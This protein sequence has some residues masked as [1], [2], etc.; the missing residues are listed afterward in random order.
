MTTDDRETKLEH[1]RTEFLKL[2]SALHDRTTDLPAVPVLTPQVRKMLDTRHH[3]GVLHVEIS[4]LDDVES[5]YGWQVFDE[6]LEVV[7]EVLRAELAGTLPAGSLLGINGVGGD[8]FAVFVPEQ[9]SG[10]E[11][12]M[13]WLGDLATKIRSDLEAAFATDEFAGL[14]PKL[15]IQTGHALLSE[16]PFYRFERRIHAAVDEARTH[17]ARRDSLRER[18]WGEELKR[19]IRDSAVSTVFQPV[20]DLETREIFGYEALTRGPKDTRFEMPGPMFALSDRAGVAADLDRLCRSTALRLWQQE[21]GQ[22]KVFVNVLPGALADPAWLDG[23]LD[24]LVDGVD[25]RLE[26][27][28]LEISERAADSQIE[29]F[30]SLVEELKDHGVGVALDDVGTG[31]ATLATLEKVRPHFLKIDATVVR[32]IHENLIKQELISSLVL[33]AEKI[34][35][36]VIAEGVETDEE[37]EAL[38]DAG[39]RY[40]QGYLFAE[41]EDADAAF[42][43]GR[44]DH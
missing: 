3:V 5:L 16:D 27:L 6:V 15:A 25:V 11:V 39:A 7:A 32:D 35:A 37:A 4:N 22:G 41:P 14:S 19:I 40:G 31:Y 2:R 1:Y 20:V 34:G 33:I 10:D 29:H 13:A 12:E 36:A 28:V 30:A 23:G 43:R 42:A 17:S 44:T 26:D 9:P 18:S 24:A 38:K 8:H 21:S